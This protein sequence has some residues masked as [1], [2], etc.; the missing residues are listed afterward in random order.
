MQGSG[1]TVQAALLFVVLPTYVSFALSSKS[2]DSLFLVAFVFLVG[3]GSLT[4]CKFGRERPKA[5]LGH[6]WSPS[7]PL[8][9]S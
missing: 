7:V 8:E 9:S 4:L 3:V 2:S 5:F 6:F 1:F